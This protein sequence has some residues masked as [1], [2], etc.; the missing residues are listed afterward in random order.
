MTDFTYLEPD[1][2]L[3]FKALLSALKTQGHT[4]I[5]QNLAYATCSINTTQS[6]SRRRWNAFATFLEIA[7][8]LSIYNSESLELLE[9]KKDI[10]RTIADEIMPSK[11]GFDIMDVK[12][13]P[14]LEVT[15]EPE[16]EVNEELQ[17]AISQ[18]TQELQNLMI[19]DNLINSAKDMSEVY[20]YTYCAENSIRTL[21]ENISR[22][23]HSDN[24]L[25]NILTSEMK[26]KIDSRKRD[27]DKWRWISARGDTD[28]YYLDFED[29][30]DIIKNNWSLFSHLF[31]SQD[32][33]CVKIK[34]MAKLRNPIAHHCNIGEDEKL[35]I[36][37]SY[38]QILAQVQ[39][40]LQ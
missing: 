22:E 18:A 20:G 10:I 26:R 37:L 32:W 24:F 17:R 15:D 33:I 12:F 4:D 38:R 40:H 5:E 36:K 19:P 9:S 34:E 31:P 16:L 30:A 27:A 14:S 6:F 8:P 29:L 11:A 7:L 23:R 2:N 13:L 3:F 39:S 1:N 21:I 35:Q 28:I 25:D